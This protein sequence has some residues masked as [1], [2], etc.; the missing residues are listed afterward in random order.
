[1]DAKYSGISGNKMAVPPPKITTQ[2]HA[3][4]PTARPESKFSDRSL[5]LNRAL[6]P[7]R[8]MLE[9]SSTA[10]PSTCVC[11]RAAELAAKEQQINS[12]MYRESQQKEEIQRL[13]KIIEELGQQIEEKDQAIVDLQEQMAH[14]EQ[15]YKELYSQ[16]CVRHEGTRQ[17]LQEMWS[18]VEKKVALI[19]QL[20]DQHQD[21]L[22]RL[23]TEMETKLA[24][25]RAE[26]ER[27]ISVRDEKLNKLK[28]Q[29]AEALKGNSWERQQQLDELSKEL[30]RV[31][32]ESE[33]LKMRIKAINK[34]GSSGGSNKNSACGNCDVMRKQLTF[35]QAL[36]KERDA[37]IGELKT[38]CSKFEKQLTQ[39]DA[40]LT[41]FAESKGYKPTDNFR[42]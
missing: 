1:M 8:R 41:Q 5:V 14:Q 16:E 37:S 30:Q 20:K 13:Q 29:M 18:D 23:S 24:A 27:E 42:K 2:V 31:Q 33:L 3:E 7:Q 26:K 19:A 9:S 32:E 4:V 38:L 36:L 17:T 39:Q 10:E 22:Q 11:N 15:K 35:T 34:G 40:L 25:E 12:Y 28:K 6:T 21:E